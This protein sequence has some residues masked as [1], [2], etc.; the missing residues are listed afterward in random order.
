VQ[1]DARV[2]ARRRVIAADET[3]RVDVLRCAVPGAC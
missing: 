1:S 2:L 3:A